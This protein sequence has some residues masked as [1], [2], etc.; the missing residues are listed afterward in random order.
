MLNLTASHCISPQVN[1]HS[2]AYKKEEPCIDGS[3]ALILKMLGGCLL[4]EYWIARNDR[5]SKFSIVLLILYFFGHPHQTLRV[6]E[7]LFCIEHDRWQI[8]VL[9]RRS[10]FKAKQADLC[11]D[12]NMESNLKFS[13]GSYHGI[14]KILHTAANWQKH[15]FRK[16]RNSHQA[17]HDIDT[18]NI[19]ATIHF[20]AD[21]LIR[22]A[23]TH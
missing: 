9:I 17:V 23:K 11:A 13:S 14:R 18:V 5:V 3:R 15:V 8:N 7:S 4:A 12:R 22:A 6:S 19:V 2:C 16:G 10:H 20:M 21:I 1:H